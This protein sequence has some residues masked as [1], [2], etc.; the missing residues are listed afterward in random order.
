MFLAD[1]V[2]PY[3]QNWPTNA[4]AQ[5]SLSSTNATRPIPFR[6]GIW[7]SHSASSPTTAKSTPS[8]VTS[9]GCAPV[10]PCWHIHL[11]GDDVADLCP[12]ILN[13]DGSDTACLDN[14]LEPLV[15]TGT[16]LEQAMTMMV[17][18]AWATKAHLPPRVRGYYEYWATMME[19]W[20]G[21]ANLVA[22]DGV[23]IVAS[24]DRNGLRPARYW[25]TTDREIVY[26]SEAGILD[27]EPGKIERKGRLAPGRTIVID[28]SSGTFTE[29]AE[30]KELLA[31]QHDYASWVRDYKISLDDLPAPA[32]P[33]MRSHEFLRKRQQA[34]G[35]TVEEL[36]MILA[37]MCSD[38][39]EAV[40]SMGVDTPLAVLSNHSKTLYWYFKQLFAQVTNPPIDPIREEVV[41][42][43]TQY[44]GPARNISCSLAPNTAACCKLISRS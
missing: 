29:N 2:G 25:I 6:P 33:P 39:Q 32:T 28:T 26:G 9:T 5:Q 44:L 40:G 21:P 30:V 15:A 35:Y 11:L 14:V 37:P 43:L 12:V 27:I 34:F 16:P 38:G 42:S 22:C 24:L 1:Q 20:D 41:M 3:Y 7:L 36:R 23:K 10:K 31:A 19:P 8:A 13:E 18:E 17:P 4:V